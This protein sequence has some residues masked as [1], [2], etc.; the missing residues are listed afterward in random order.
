MYEEWRD[1]FSKVYQRGDLDQELFIKHAYLA[2]LIKTVLISKLVDDKKRSHIENLE[3]II[4]VFEERGVPI[5]LN[6]FFQWTNEEEIVQNEIFIAVYNSTFIIDDLF[7]T[8]YQ[9][10]VSPTTRHALGE[11][12][13]PQPL[14]EK[15]VEEVYEFGQSVLDPACG[16]G[17]FLVQIL[18]TINNANE[19]DKKKI[20][21]I[22]RLYGF[23]INPIAVLV[24]R[25]NLLLL[26]D[27]IFGASSKIQINIFLADSLNP[28]NDFV[29]D[30]DKTKL[31]KKGLK[32]DE[33]RKEAKSIVSLEKW[34]ASLYGE[35]ERFSMTAINDSIVINI[36]F[37]KYSDLFGDIL[38]E[39]DRHLSKEL[40]F[41]EL[42]ELIYK[43][44]DTRWLEE[45]C[46]GSEDKTLRD[47]F[48]Y[49]AQKF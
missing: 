46:E 35:S 48:E 7:R 9:E 14:A 40:R 10:M 39:L 43:N 16:S 36:N 45:F 23:D 13:T 38:K 30:L 4:E 37:F 25:S 49:M 34:G 19:S 1:R 20:E 33:R 26:T 24:A 21:A 5:F 31:Y 41:E 44:L 29:S 6:D 47:N 12:Y 22:S 2:L 27:K 28:I 18:K 42:L 11:F 17:T 32:D 15:M 3:K 8:I